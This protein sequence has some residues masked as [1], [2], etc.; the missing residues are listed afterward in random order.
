MQW[1]ASQVGI[2]SFVR[3]KPGALERVRIYARRHDLRHPVLL[4]SS[5]LPESVTAP[6]REAFA[7][8][9]IEPLRQ[10][11]VKDTCFDSVARLLAALPAQ[12]DAVFRGRWRQVSGRGQILGDVGRAPLLRRS[13]VVV[14]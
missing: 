10:L 1:K 13:H 6:V 3:I 5:G 4:M 14:Q 9:R 7:A 12:C 8:K 2:P 11:E